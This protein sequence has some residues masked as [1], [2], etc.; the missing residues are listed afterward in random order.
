MPQEKG[1]T[2][3]EVAV[4][5]VILGLLI[6][7]TFPL[8]TVI[9]K[10][11]K[12]SDTKERANE[13]K[14][15]LIQYYRD[16][17]SLPSPSSD[18]CGKFSVPYTTLGLP[19]SSRYD[20]VTGACF[21]YVSTNNG[22][23]FKELYVDGKP[24][25]STAA[26][27]V[28]KGFNASFD[29]ENA[30]PRNGRFQSQSSNRGFDDVLISVTQSELDAAT[31]WVREVWEDIADLNTAAKILAANDDD[32]DGQIDED[33]SSSPCP[34][35]DPPGNCD[36][37]FNWTRIDRYGVDALLQAGLLRTGDRAVDPWGT[38]Y[39]W[40]GRHQTF[41]SAGPNKRDEGGRGDDLHP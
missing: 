3:V 9:T 14:T 20:A 10:K 41:Y 34:T 23:P 28:S 35:M 39:I 29:Y 17:L 27:I 7:S 26:V 37:K 2:L 31:W 32:N 5:M 11:Q 6:A 4:L 25:G 1:F 18:N 21:M 22:F 15:A 36:G 38:S 24:I 30:N 13:I 33:P 12:L 8:Y 16:H 19:L 40:D